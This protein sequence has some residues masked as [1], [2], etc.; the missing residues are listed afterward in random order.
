[1]GNQATA[2]RPEAL[3][4]LEDSTSLSAEEIRRFYKEFMKDCP[5]G[6]MTMS[7]DDFQKVYARIFPE[8][9]A[10]KFASHVFK[11]LDGD[12]SGR[13]DFREFIQAISVQMKGSTEQKLQWVFDLYDLDGTGFI[14]KNELLEM[15][16]SQY[17][18]KGSTI[19]PDE[20]MT[21]DQIVDYILEK[22]DDNKDEKLSRDEF[23]KGAM[24]SRTIQRLL[25]GTLEATRSPFKS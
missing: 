18:L 6:R 25:S 19:S 16:N 21:P 4:D 2:L 9:D 1:M 11:H 7:L 15:V 5:S 22:A 13:I 10:K 17:R 3:T 14:E 23:T 24:Q 8:G 12:A 20:N